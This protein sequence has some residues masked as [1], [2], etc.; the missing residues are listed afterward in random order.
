MMLKR[1]QTAQEGAPIP[2][3]NVNFSKEQTLTKR[4]CH[5]ARRRCDS[6]AFN[7]A[8][9]MGES[10]RVPDDRLGRLCAK[11]DYCCRRDL[12]SACERRG[13]IIRL[14]RA[15]RVLTLAEYHRRKEAV[16][17]G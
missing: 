15:K 2:M 4:L 11:P 17:A 1:Q 9:D 3:S 14:P 6:R 10:A 13:H 12:F 16:C 7:Y 5:R 8:A